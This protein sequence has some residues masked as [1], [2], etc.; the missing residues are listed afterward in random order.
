VALREGMTV[1][2]RLDDVA[3]TSVEA[4]LVQIFP[5]A[6]PTR[7]TVRVKFDIPKNSPAAPGMYVEVLI[8]EPGAIGMDLPVVPKNAIFHRGGLPM[9]KVVNMAG[10]TELRLVR[11]GERVGS[12]QR[13]VLAGVRPGERVVVN[14]H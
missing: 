13:V 9:V 6:D 11:L 14:D 8:P 10:H 4:S 1:K 5:M 3:D 2:A 12:D 7:H